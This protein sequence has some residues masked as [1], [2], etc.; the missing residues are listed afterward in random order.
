MLA[1]LLFC[2]CFCSLSTCTAAAAAAAAAAHTTPLAN[3]FGANPDDD[4]EHN[5]NE[6]VIYNLTTLYDLA[7]APIEKKTSLLERVATHAGDDFNVANLKLP[8]KR[9]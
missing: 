3:A 8:D 6:S 9:Y 5:I 2:F 7:G 4:P 1:W